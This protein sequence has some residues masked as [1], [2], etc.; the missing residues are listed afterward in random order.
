VVRVSSLEVGARLG[1]L[2]I[3]ELA[4][5][6]DDT[7][8]RIVSALVKVHVV[9]LDETPADPTAGLPSS[10]YGAIPGHHIKLVAPRATLYG[11]IGTDQ[12]KRLGRKDVHAISGLHC[13]M[14][15]I[16]WVTGRCRHFMHF[17]SPFFF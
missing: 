13:E 5:P 1:N 3:R 9:F 8:L 14:G 10:L 16:A 2:L 12:R 7:A 17:G 4:V 15:L 11:I 6:T